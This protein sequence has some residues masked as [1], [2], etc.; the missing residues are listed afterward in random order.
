M[1]PNSLLSFR[2]GKRIKVRGT[3]IH[4][5][6]FKCAEEP[7]RHSGKAFI[8]VL[9]ATLKLLR[10]GDLKWMSHFNAFY[11]TK[12]KPTVA[13]PVCM[14]LGII[15]CPFVDRVPNRIVFGGS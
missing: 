9:E 2:L 10:V 14:M 1:K 6:T 8:L 11:I 3:K 15:C 12:T 7:I 13:F 5:H 4:I